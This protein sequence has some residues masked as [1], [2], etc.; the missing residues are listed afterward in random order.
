M[1]CGAVMAIQRYYAINEWPIEP[2]EI[3]HYEHNYKCVFCNSD[4][5]D[6]KQL[7]PEYDVYLC[8]HCGNYLDD[9][10]TNSHASVVFG[11]D[12]ITAYFVLD[13][14]EY[15]WSYMLIC[16]QERYNYD[17]H[18]EGTGVL[19]RSRRLALAAGLDTLLEIRG[20]L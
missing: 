14:P 15:G 2:T 16:A 1:T 5:Q 9:L 6:F 11:G 7:V 13:G 10:E 4:H 3:L 19:F 8:K 12:R 18:E 20:D 17:D